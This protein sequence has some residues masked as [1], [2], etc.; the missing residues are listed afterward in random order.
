MG[1]KI[2]GIREKLSCFSEIYE[3][4][5][6]DLR[7]KDPPHSQRCFEE[8]ETFR[9]MAEEIVRL[10]P[11]KPEIEGGGTSWFFVCGECHTSINPKDRFCRGCGRPLEWDETTSG[12]T[13]D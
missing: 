10:E 8:A 5:A 6:E 12:N 2:Q 7:E 1:N 9:R 13:Q 3:K 11:V 4:L